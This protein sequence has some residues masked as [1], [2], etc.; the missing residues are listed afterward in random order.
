MPEKELMNFPGAKSIDKMSFA[1]GSTDY[2]YF[3][4]AVHWWVKIRPL[5]KKTKKKRAARKKKKK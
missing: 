1:P 2:I 4:T 5:K 3:H